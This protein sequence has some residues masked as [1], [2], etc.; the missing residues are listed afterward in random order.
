MVTVVNLRGGNLTSRN[1][2]SH[3]QFQASF[4][5]FEQISVGTM[6][7]MLIGTPGM[8]MYRVKNF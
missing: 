8:E 3:I 4:F 6:C 2:F 7:N 1:P 5:K